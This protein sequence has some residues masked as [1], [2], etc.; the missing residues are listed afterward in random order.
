MWTGMATTQDSKTGFTL[1]RQCPSTLNHWN[2]LP[3]R[4]RPRNAE[5]AASCPY[6]WWWDESI[7]VNMV[8]TFSD[9][10]PDLSDT[11]AP[12]KRVLQWRKTQESLP[13]FD[14]HWKAK[15]L[16]ARHAVRLQSRDEKAGCPYFKEMVSTIKTVRWEEFLCRWLISKIK[17]NGK[18]FL[19]ARGENLGKTA[20]YG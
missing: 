19:S 9:L 14:D 10:K 15:S 13:L 12:A 5:S 20:G 16:E 8:L 2:V 7:S 3:P 4:R 18:R 17:E 1:C 11:E 6:Q